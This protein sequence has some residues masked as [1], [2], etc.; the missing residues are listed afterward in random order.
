MPNRTRYTPDSHTN[1]R[2]T[3][4]NQSNTFLLVC[5]E[6]TVE[7]LQIQNFFDRDSLARHR[8]KR[9]CIVKCVCERVG[10]AFLMTR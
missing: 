8:K 7:V 3:S 6:N 4:N 1:I 10:T 9:V 5:V 2:N